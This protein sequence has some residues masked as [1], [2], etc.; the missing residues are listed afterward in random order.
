MQHS[1]NFLTLF[2][3]GFFIIHSPLLLANTTQSTRPLIS[4]E[5]EFV[6]G[7]DQSLEDFYG[8]EDFVSI[9]TGNKV[10]IHKAP[11]VAT[12]ITAEQIENMGAKTVSEALE[13][14]PGLHVYPS[15]FNRLNTSF[16]IRGI[17]T[18]QNP[19]ILYLV[20][21]LPVREEYT[22]ARPQAFKM[23]VHSVAR[24][25]VIRGPG[26]AVYGADAYAGV[27]N[28]ITKDLNKIKEANYGGSYGLSLIHI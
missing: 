13:N 20:N 15:P 11:S 18:D 5:E 9:A 12:V 27:I 25:E 23:P 16:S 19:Q 2:I 28:V 21:G 26:S 14:V 6:D 10:L 22:G 24:I 4:V 7:G 1:R 8:D 17:Y 3:S